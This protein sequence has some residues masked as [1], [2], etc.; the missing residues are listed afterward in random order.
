MLHW[1]L[2]K[3]VGS[4]NQRELKKL[5]P[6]VQQINR[7]EQ[8]LQSK[9]E[10]V[11]K[12]KTAA[13][14]AD[15]AKINDFQEVQAYLT[16]ILPEAFA[17]VKNGAR[18]LAGSKILVCDQPIT[19]EMV[20]FDVQLL[21]GMALHNGKI[22]EMATGEGKT[23][24]ATLPLYLNGLT[25]KGVHLIT[26]NDYLARR[27]AEWMGFLLQ[28]LGV[29]VGC[30]QHDQPPHIRREQ[31]AA[32]VTYG[33]NSEFGFDYLRDNG[34]ASSVEEQVQRGHWFAIVD[35]VDSV[36][37]DEARTPLIISGPVA[38]DTHQYDKFKPM[39]EKVVKEQGLLLNQVAAEAKTLGEAN[40]YDEAGHLLFKIKL[41]QPRHRALLRMMEEPEYRRAMEKAELSY[42]SD[43]Q[44]KALF[45]LKEELFYSID[46]KSHESDLMEK[47]RKFLSPDDPDAFVLPDLATSFADIEQNKSLSPEER[48]AAKEAVQQKMDV[49]AQR[50]HNI[51]QLLRAYCLY[52]K[53][54]NY[55]VGSI[56]KEGEEPGEP[57]VIILDEH[58]GR[59]M[60]GRRWS[61]GLHQAV[62]AKEGV[63][64]DK[65]TQTLATIT[66]QNYFRLYKKLAGMT[67]TA[68]T[69]ASEFHDIYKLDMLIV[70][71][72]RPIQRKDNND[73]IYKTR[74]EKYNA[75]IE[76]IKERH[77]TG[78]PMLIGTASVDASETL[79]RMMRGAKIPHQVLNAKNHLAEA[80]IVAQAGQRG[81][82][83]V[84]TNM[85]G[86]GTDIK[87]G[88]GIPELGGLLV[89][90]TERHEARRI[91]RQLRG[92]CARQGDPGESIFYISFEDQL[93]MNFGAAGRM[94]GLMEKMGL[95]DGQ[96]LEHPWLN[97]SVESA[98]K[99]VEQRNYTY[100]K[101]TLEFDD[102]LNKQRT[103]IY[104]YRNDALTVEDP[105][106]MVL[107]VI[108]EAIPAKVQGFLDPDTNKLDHAALLQWVNMTFPL[109]LTHEEA[110]LDSRDIEG[111]GAWLVEKVK[112]AYELKTG[113]EFPEAVKGLERY[114][115]LNA[116][117][118]LWQEHLYNMDSL[119]DGVHLRS[120]AQKDPLQEYKSEAYDLFE[121]LMGNIKNEVLNNLFRS[122]TNLRAFEE[123]LAGLPRR[124]SGGGAEDE[125][126]PP[127]SRRPQQRPAINMG[128]S[129]TITLSGGMVPKKKQGGTQ[130]RMGG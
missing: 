26:V 63:R 96:E 35:E 30:I 33:T 109:R 112:A 18:R 53:D 83:T 15:L 32:D 100:R 50:M 16:K 23:L 124:L 1:I 89:I 20:H 118:R 117:D 57:K 28:Y 66:I 3:I 34:L 74:R 77:A 82:I 54:V 72:N 114:V 27:D 119:R 128:G 36:L 62:E 125:T 101:R 41:G 103:V 76:L 78:Q 105:H 86:R 11:L 80:G 25:G 60:P 88:P 102:V 108:D 121:A 93:M 48:L 6:L 95:Q 47:G 91:D 107:E 130:T 115:L 5:W 61:D 122:T 43:P 46:E 22:A 81:A 8:E 65:E 59:P 70:P 49:Q 31:Y 68:E 90:A 123:L 17:V 38:H 21:G 56:H 98:Q 104:E 67:G 129:G 9:P 64:I 87:L 13:W 99:R 12:Q 120:F 7:L 71:T 79:S 51:S 106:A 110:N 24:V 111:N 45:A 14:K 52:E 29:T 75:V 4:K 92:R 55:M 116:I 39:V 69:E 85:A 2:R 37:I 58:T 10:E 44:K 113:T 84:S 40:K 126:P 97:R 19:W 127:Q 42:Y 94:T 73:K